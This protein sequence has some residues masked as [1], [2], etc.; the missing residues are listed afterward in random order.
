MKLWLGLILSFIGLFLSIWIVIPAPNFT[1]LPLA[2]GSPEI[3]PILI[4]GNSI[5]LLLSFS[6]SKYF[7]LS[8]IAVSCSL[9]ALILS[10][11]PLWQLPTTIQQAQ[12]QMQ[13]VLGNWQIPADLQAKMRPRPFVLADLFT[14]LA[15]PKVRQSSHTFAA[16]DGTPL[17]LEIYQPMVT[18]RYP[19]IAAI[20]GGAW[21]RGKPTQNARFNSYIAA[22]GYTVVAI[23]Y[24]HAPRYRFPAQL[25]DVAA[26]L[27]FMIQQAE[28]YEIDPTRIAVIG[29][30]SGG[31]LATLAA[32]QLNNIPIRAVINYY[33]PTNLLQ[34]YTDPPSPD[35]INTKAVLQALLGGSP[36]QVPTLYQEA[37]PINH[38]KPNLPPTLLIY[39]DR[40]H[41]VK[42]IFGQ[43]LYQRLQA[44]GNK[45]IF[46]KIPWAEHSFDAVF[47]GMGN[48]IALYHIER[49]LAWALRDGE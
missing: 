4:I 10:C 28:T 38:V 31:H 22:Q 17:S 32:Y 36:E 23:D 14:G 24:R 26:A 47:N 16:A 37:S 18:G 15:K 21:Q 11:I 39:G 34:G 42:S 12:T 7:L 2:V 40:D 20:Y 33:A 13:A 48:Q 49:F 43:Q 29:W 6:Q 25:Q 44:T 1:L 45:A 8:R 46:L 3:S 19:A 41:L 30:S 35:P 27:Q 5:A 9:L